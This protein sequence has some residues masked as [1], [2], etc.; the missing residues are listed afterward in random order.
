MRI[1]IV[2]HKMKKKGGM[3]LQHLKMSK[4]FEKNGC[5]VLVF[6]FDDYFRTRNVFFN[7][8]IVYKNLHKT[9]RLFNPEIILT[10]D[11]YF[12][13]LF[14]LVAKKKSTPLVLRIGAIFHPFYAARIIERISPGKIYV[15][16]FYFINFLFKQLDKL[17]LKKCN[18]VI[19]NSNFLRKYYRNSSSSSVVIYNGVDKITSKKPRNNNLLNLVYIGRI[20]PRKSIE[21]ILNSLVILKKRNV[22]FHFSL[23]GNTTL[24][25][26][27]W[28]KLEN[29]IKS[30]NLLENITIYGKIP[31]RDT[32]AILEKNDIL[33]FSTDERNFPMT[34]GLPNAILEGMAA[35]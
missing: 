31:N 22:K 33:L 5:E 14:S 21:I 13:T 19:F 23:I 8:L 28:M 32:L 2:L 27:Y 7:Y 29:L 30:N 18:L 24:Y 9:I 10:S 12:S 6:S 20:E 15:R 4:Q 11:P 3:V 34:E 16:F 17:I 25:A 35:G 26:E 1:L